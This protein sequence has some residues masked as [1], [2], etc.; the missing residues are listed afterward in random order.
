[1]LAIIQARC[2]SQRFANKILKIIYGKPLIKHVISRVQKAKKITKIV[3][4]TSKNKS[5]DKLVE[6]LKKI[7]VQYY[8]G[9]LSNVA[10]RMV[11]A[12]ERQKKLYFLRINGDSPLID[13]DIIDKAISIFRKNKNY[14]LISNVFPRTF[15]KGQSV[16]I[17]RTQ[18]LKKYL[19]NMNKIEKEHITQYFYINSDIFLIKNF[20]NKK[21]IKLIKTAVDS[22]KDLVNILRNIKKNEFENYSISKS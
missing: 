17:I 15:P 14:D 2:N 20:V 5:D 16:E 10:Q 8:R 21:K 1:M 18:V 3:V 4:A 12:A 11:R 9:S 7:K 13:P 22:K 19:K 6:Y